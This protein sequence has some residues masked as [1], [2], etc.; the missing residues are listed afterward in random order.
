MDAAS[1]ARTIV[2]RRTV[3]ST[4]EHRARVDA[5]KT[6]LVF[7]ND[8]G[9]VSSWTYGD[10][11]QTVNRVAGGLSRL[12]MRRGERINLHMTNRPEFLF[13]WFA[14][15]KLG[16]VMVPTNPLSPPDELAYP[17]GHSE[18][19]VT[20]TLPQLLENVL[21]ARRRCPALRS[22]IVCGRP[23]GDMGS[24]AAPGEP[25]VI[26]FSELCR[27]QP[28]RPPGID[29]DP[30]S[31]VAI[32]YTSGTTSRPKGVMVTNANYVF[33]GEQISKNVGLTPDDRWL[34]TLPL[35]HGNAQYYSVM[36][37][38]TVGAS[39]AVM[40]RFSASRLMRQAAKH[41]CTVHS[42]LA[43]PL[44]MV[45]AQK[46][47]ETD[48]LS[49]LRLVIFAQSLTPEQY[50][51]WDRRYGV[52]LLQIFGMTET[53][54]QPLV[55]P[56]NYRRDHSTIG[57]PAMGYECRV[58]DENGRDVPSGG[59]GQLI[60]SGIPG[61]TIMRG[62]L[63][64]PENTER[65]LRD[66]WLWTGDVVRV[67]EDGY[68][69]FLDRARELIRRSGENISA[70]EVEA[71]LKSHPAVEDAAVI[72]LPDEM[73]DESVNAFVV[74]TEGASAPEDEIME[75]CRARLS[76]FKV[77]GSIDFR[78]DFPRTSTGKVRKVELKEAA[79]AALRR[80]TDGA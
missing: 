7:E 6:F 3:A 15:A 14:A 47:H 39:L 25:D 16:A 56:L 58:V 12:G 54:G 69:H 5:E 38:L 45:L 60:V 66:G 44:R 73:Y 64:D 78:D 9:E 33:L 35:F 23:G 71:V 32:L 77:P 63:R 10:F 1:A 27:G 11:N 29:Q 2:G 26:E 17:L 36:T 53:M 28:D 74:L 34:V 20:V 37:A 61:V 72:G 49:G 55:N 68:F 51:E 59:A 18:A 65:T 41:G 70:G 62:Y 75:F 22:V 19:V 52:P 57:L 48:G 31:D 40:S 4:L 50:E 43:T 80:D 46:P 13:F 24:D 8:L 79:L 67:G 76:K 42:S 30:L 21:A